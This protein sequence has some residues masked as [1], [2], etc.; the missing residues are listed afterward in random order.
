MRICAGN[1][2]GKAKHRPRSCGLTTH[3]S[4]KS[5][6]KAQGH[7]DVGGVGGGWG[8]G[9]GRGGDHT[10]HGMLLKHVLVTVDCLGTQGVGPGHI[11]A[12]YTRNSNNRK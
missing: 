12:S 7:W 3:W 11:I 8:R 4:N 2:C 6:G 1:E 9:G 5:L 10:P